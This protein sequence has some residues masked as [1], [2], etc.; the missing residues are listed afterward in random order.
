MQKAEDVHFILLHV[1]MQILGERLRAVLS[2]RATVI[3]RRHSQRRGKK[4][5]GDGRTE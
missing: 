4:P 5:P 1:A 2:E 3:D